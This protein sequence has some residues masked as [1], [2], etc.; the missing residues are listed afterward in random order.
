MTETDR[1]STRRK[2]PLAEVE[3]DDWSKYVRGFDIPK[4]EAGTGDPAMFRAMDALL[5]KVT[6]PGQTLLV[7]FGSDV[8]RA[9]PLRGQIWPFVHDP[10]TRVITDFNGI[11]ARGVLAKVLGR[12]RRAVEA[13]VVLAGS[14]S[15]GRAAALLAGAAAIQDARPAS[16]N[17]R[18]A[19]GSDEPTP[20]TTASFAG[21]VVATEAGDEGTVPAGVW[22]D[23]EH[24]D[25]ERERVLYATDEFPPSIAKQI[26][27]G[28]PFRVL[29][30]EHAAGDTIISAQRFTL[31]QAT[32]LSDSEKKRRARIAAAASAL[33]ADPPTA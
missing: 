6:F 17:T 16:E 33:L 8:H 29:R 25:G 24:D 28:H 30:R 2:Q 18:M 19:Q 3:P 13:P 21:V 15:I 10:D 31:V 26:L 12:A 22:V 4:P 20:A 7:T 23:I 5:T 11:D 14:G 27:A 1:S 9:K 32:A